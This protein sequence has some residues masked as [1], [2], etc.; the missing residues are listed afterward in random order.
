MLK[1]IPFVYSQTQ[2]DL[3]DQFYAETERVRVPLNCIGN[4]SLG[5]ASRE[6]WI[7]PGI[8]GYHTLRKVPNPFKERRDTGKS[9]EFLWEKYASFLRQFPNSE[10]LVRQNPALKK[11]PSM[12]E[13]ILDA[14]HQ[15]KPQWLSVP[16]LPIVNGS[17]NNKINTALARATSEWREKSG[18]NGT[19]IVPMI[20]T[21][22]AGQYDKKMHRNAKIGELKK[23]YERS[24]ADGIWIVDSDLQ[25]YKGVGTYQ[26]RLEQL[27]KLHQEVRSKLPN[28]VLVG[29]PYWGMNLVL[30]ARGLCDHPAI[31]VGSGFRYQIPGM[32]PQTAKT[33]IALASLRRWV[34]LHPELRRW[35]GSVVNAPHSDSA[36]TEFE[37]ILAQFESFMQSKA[38][39]RKQVAKFYRRWIHEHAQKS[40]HGRALNLF[41]DLSAAYVVGSQLEE[42]PKSEAPGRRP[43]VVAQHLMLNCL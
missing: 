1:F 29:G 25:D 18:Y 39:A 30:W 19:L 5:S 36:K 20:L 6:L 15:H 27:V 22:Y 10:D 7:D 31:G 23:C 32:S 11:I 35:L 43:E 42:F 12:V 21:R 24:T 9:G 40:E 37:A 34:Q 26:K 16:Q 4:L 3:V 2:Y 8:D 17:A 33:R 38:L 14:C 13:G 41:Q 28:A